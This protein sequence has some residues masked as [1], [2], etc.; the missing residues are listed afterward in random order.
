ME[1][2]KIN[3]KLLNLG[4]ISKKWLLSS[5]EPLQFG[6]L[7]LSDKKSLNKCA[8]RLLAS[9]IFQLYHGSQLYCWWKPEYPE[10]TTALS[11][12]TDKLYH[13]MLYRVHLAKQ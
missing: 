13:I 6:Q 1:S 4:Q 3:L 2:N 7:V 5:N 9:T 8:F 11:Q 12:V 10:K